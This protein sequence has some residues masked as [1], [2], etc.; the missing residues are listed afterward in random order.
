MRIINNNL[1]IYILI[2]IQFSLLCMY[3]RS[4][5]HVIVLFGEPFCLQIITT[6]FFLNVARSKEVLVQELL[7]IIDITN[8]AGDLRIP[9][10]YKYISTLA[11]VH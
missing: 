8:I 6:N 5:S 11:S 2:T 3:E 9:M 4:N 10:I 7:H 1:Y